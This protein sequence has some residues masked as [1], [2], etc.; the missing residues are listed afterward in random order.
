MA[1]SS[2]SLGI[3]SSISPMNMLDMSL[4]IIVFGLVLRD[5]SEGLRVCPSPSLSNTAEVCTKLTEQGS[6]LVSAH[7]QSAMMVT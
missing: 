7:A 3:S 1:E 6:G 4:D 2:P 5:W